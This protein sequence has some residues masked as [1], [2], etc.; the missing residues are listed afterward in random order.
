M[1]SVVPRRRED[2]EL[3]TEL[4]H[5]IGGRVRRL[6]QQL[7]FTQATISERL[8]MSAE[9]YGRIER[10]SSLP[11]FPTFVRVCE[12]LST[13]PDL[14]LTTPRA[15]VMQEL[16]SPLAPVMESP[17]VYPI[18]E[19]ETETD[20]MIDEIRCLDPEARLALAQVVR[21]LWNRRQGKYSEAD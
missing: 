19:T 14:L 16:A 9:A 17:L 4:A 3:A 7:G 18:D 21:L 1:E 12:V 13:S 8:G 6:R 2:E 11:S 20:S 10:G 5:R 15:V